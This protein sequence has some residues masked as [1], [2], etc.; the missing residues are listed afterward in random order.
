M[1]VVL[2]WLADNQS[3]FIDT[4]VRFATAAVIWIIGK[5]IIKKIV[6][7]AT[8]AMKAGKTEPAVAEFMALLLGIL[9]KVMLFIAVLGQIGVDSSPFTAI[10]AGAIFTIAYA[11]QENLSHMAAGVVILML[12]LFKKDDLIKAADV[13]GYI[14]NVTVMFTKVRTTNGRLVICPNGNVAYNPIV[15]ATTNKV[16]RAELPFVVESEMGLKRMREFLLLCALENNKVEQEP[17]PDVVLT[18]IGEEALTLVLRCWVRAEDYM[19]FRHE[20]PE[21]VYRR[22]ERSAL[23][24]APEDD[25][26]DDGADGADGEGEGEGGDTGHGDELDEKEEA[27]AATGE[28]AAAKAE[29]R[30]VSA[31]NFPTD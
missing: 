29:V 22:F 5:F 2:D 24:L 4:A 19:N 27:D 14:D 13:T 10:L 25:E 30:K 9:L 16:M 15:N 20:L 28:T 23:S 1:S 18:H 21:E 31:N 12:R 7:A 6:L 17:E 8:T 26:D 3:S 11:M